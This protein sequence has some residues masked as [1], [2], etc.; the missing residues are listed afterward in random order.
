MKSFK[1]IF[2][3]LV[4]VLFLSCV[5]KNEP[6][7]KSEILQ[8]TTWM[9]ESAQASG[10]LSGLVYQRGKTAEG[11]QYDMSKI[12]VTFYA[13]GKVSAIDN[14]G[15]AQ[16][17]GKWLLS[18]NETKIN[19]SSAGNDLLNGIG[20]IEVLTTSNFTFSGE[21]TYQGQSVKATIKMIPAL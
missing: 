2:L 3:L 16:T 7:T 18:D 6:V 12:R 11:S 15:N 19:I 10:Y 8:S 1:I 9:V 4:S 5:K 14:T 21:R 17:S 13:D 20:L